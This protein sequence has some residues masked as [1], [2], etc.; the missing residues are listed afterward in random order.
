[1]D[2][3]DLESEAE[4]SR[5]GFVDIDLSGR[6]AESVRFE[7]CKFTGVD[8]S[9]STLSQAT[10]SD[11]HFGRSNLANLRAE[12]SSLHR[13]ELSVLRMTGFT[14]VDGLLR[15][16]RFNEC[17]L[18]LSSFRFTEATGVVFEDCNLT[19]ADFSHADLGGAQFLGCDLTGA[20]F[21]GAEMAGARFANCT[22]IDIG[23]VT[24]WSGAIV[25]ADDLVA[26]SYTLATAL[27]IV[28][29]GADG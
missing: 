3:H 14:W 6:V 15:D 8:L 11:C 13:V 1:V 27:G 22:L 19:R 25:R 24:S 2:D 12:K 4:Y 26:L 29:D 7:Q 28:I 20:Q 21:S 23:G 5:L 17:R 9:G 10:L 16:V 18:D